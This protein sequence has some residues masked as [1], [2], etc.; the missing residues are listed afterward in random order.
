MKTLLFLMAMFTSLLAHS[1]NGYADFICNINK[2][3]K[4]TQC[5]DIAEA[6]FMTVGEKSPHIKTIVAIMA[7]ESRFNKDAKSKDGAIGYM[8]VMPKYHKAS[9]EGQ[10]FTSAFVN[11][12]VGSNIY[13]ECYRKYNNKKSALVCYNGGNPNKKSPYPKRVMAFEHAL[14]EF[15]AHAQKQS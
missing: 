2:T 4:Y 1:S 12:I 6:T 10:T 8:Q 3:L 7:T 14:E 9:F 11:I 5:M 15:L 13:Y